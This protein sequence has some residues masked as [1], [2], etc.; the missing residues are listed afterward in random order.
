MLSSCED[1]YGLIDYLTKL[2]RPALTNRPAY[3]VVAFHLNLTSDVPCF[4]VR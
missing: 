4:Y 2:P 3:D 1:V